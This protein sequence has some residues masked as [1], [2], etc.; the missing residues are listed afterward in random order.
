VGV[1]PVEKPWI[2]RS[3]KN[4]ATVVKM[5]YTRLQ[6]RHTAEPTNITGRR[7]SLSAS[8]PLKGRDN[9]AVTVN[10]EIIRP[11]CSPP[12]SDVKY[13]GSSGTIILKL[14]KKSRELKHISQKGFVYTPGGFTA[15]FKPVVFVPVRP[16]RML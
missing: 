4:P 5:G 6:T 1:K 10:N 12:P 7:P 11:L 15:W 8:L 9:K 3:S 14:P 16:V 13:E 2:S